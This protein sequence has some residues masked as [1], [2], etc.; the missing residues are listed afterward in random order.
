MQEFLSIDAAIF[1]QCAHDSFGQRSGGVHGCW[2][3][4][5]NKSLR[6]IRFNTGGTNQC[7]ELKPAKVDFG[8]FECF[9]MFLVDRNRE[10]INREVLAIAQTDGHGGGSIQETA[11]EFNEHG[12]GDE[13]NALLSHSSRHFP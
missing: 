5:N 4:L 10:I 9:F 13:L 2:G 1:C 8:L 3:G 6:K 11:K 12:C 7:K